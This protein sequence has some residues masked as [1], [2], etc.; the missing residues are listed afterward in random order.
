MLAIGLG[1][2]SIGNGAAYQDMVLGAVQMLGALHR[3]LDGARG[4]GVGNKKLYGDQTMETKRPGNRATVNATS[5]R[6]VVR[7]EIV[8]CCLDMGGLVVQM[9]MRS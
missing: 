8:V 1:S 5:M 4:G 6:N 2:N 7:G 9:Q 3:M